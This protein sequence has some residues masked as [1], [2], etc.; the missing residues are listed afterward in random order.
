M[1]EVESL[2]QFLFTC[3]LDRFS[4]N[5]PENFQ[6]FSCHQICLLVMM[7]LNGNY[8]CAEC[9]RGMSF[10]EMIIC[11]R[12]SLTF[13]KDCLGHSP[14]RLLYFR[15]YH[16]AMPMICAN[17]DMKSRFE[18][19]EIQAAGLRQQL[20][21]LNETR[22]H[23][24]P[25]VAGEYWCNEAVDRMRRVNNLI[26][27]NL[28]ESN[29]VTERN[30]VLDDKVNITREI[31]SICY[32]DV[33]NIFVE[34]V[35]IYSDVRRPL[36]VQ[37]SQE[38]DV[39]TVLRNRHLCRSGLM[40][41]RDRTDFQN[42]MLRDTEANLNSLRAEGATNRRLRFIR[43]VPMIVDT[44]MIVEPEAHD[45]FE[46][47]GEIGVGNEDVLVDVENIDACEENNTLNE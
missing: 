40:F 3:P 44:Q 21:Q 11:H 43:G 6:R 31:L 25:V 37:L 24:V 39:Y 47:A 30:R 33:T 17:C 42:R 12:C 10:N 19:L 45:V 18:A 41:D 38:T 14:E 36:R 29:Q 1:D 8:L 32:I 22:D 27:Y 46:N 5:Y 15:N 7:N 23:D 2:I 20:R 35:G 4:N 28:P 13:H 26:V 9:R 34:R 16:L